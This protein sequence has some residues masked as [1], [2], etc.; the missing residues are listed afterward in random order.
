[1][2]DLFTNVFL[3]RTHTTATAIVIYNLG[4]CLVI[5]VGFYFNG[6]LMRRVR[7][8]LLYGMGC[9]LQ[10]FPPLLLVFIRPSSLLVI[11]ALGG[12]FGL[13]AGFFWANRNFL[14]LRLVQEQHRLRFTALESILSTIASV[15]MPILIGWLLLLGERLGWY[16]TQQAYEAMTVLGLLLL[17]V[18]G[19]L[20]FPIH[21]PAPNLERLWVRDARR[22]WNRIRW[23]EMLHGFQHALEMVI[24]T[25]LI[26]LLLGQEDVLGTLQSA[27]ALVASIVIYLIGTRAP[28]SSRGT[29]LAWWVAST[30]IST[31]LL[32]IFYS[33]L[34][35]IIYVIANALTVD[36]RWMALITTMYDV[37]DREERQTKNSHYSYLFD[38]EIFLSIGRVVA[39]IAFLIFYIASPQNALRATLLSGAVLQIFVFILMRGIVAR[40]TK[41]QPLPLH[42]NP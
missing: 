27:A 1:M 20:A 23:V 30:L 19:W 8:A 13:A 41:E 4:F 22:E 42:S 10:G 34:A 16:S 14:S 24:P 35:L 6:L 2:T 32:V 39:L 11:G 28:R 29:I 5:P 12:L 37:V 17:S 7:P 9:L 15:F 25:L 18:A 21:L 38:R 40:Q 26:L 31:S 3:W 36:I 33:P